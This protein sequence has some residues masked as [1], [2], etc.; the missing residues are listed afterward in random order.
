MSSENNKTISKSYEELTF[1]DDFMFCKIMENNPELCQEITELIIGR[2]IRNIIKD[3]MQKSIRISPDAKGIRFDVYLEDDEKNVYDIEMQ[4]SLLPELPKR[5]R[6]YQGMIDLQL[7][8]K[9]SRYTELKK[10][11]IIFIC[12]E[13]MFPEIGRHK[14][15]FL[16]T[17]AEEP[18]LLLGDETEKIILS[19]EGTKD[20]VSPEMS[21][22]LK[23][24]AKKE[25][26][27]DLTRR[28]DEKTKKARKDR[29]WRIEYMTLQEKLD[30]ARQEGREEERENTRRESA[31]ADAAESRADAAENRADAAESRAD[32]AENRADAAESRAKSAENQLNEKNTEI[33]R[34]KAQIKLLKA[35]KQSE[36]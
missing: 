23:Y 28:I 29:Q 8:E 21:S 17:C 22:F 11:Y 26:D 10:S 18:G 7:I 35:E 14:Y 31:R 16:S 25:A 3:D 32:A 2:K 4:A 19:A 33:D 27:S 24:L 13:N 1:T 34:L 30:E 9:G 12:L 5:I 15:T 6:Y 36:A 20:D